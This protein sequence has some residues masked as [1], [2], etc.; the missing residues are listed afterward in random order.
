MKKG[1][2][3]NEWEAKAEEE[4]FELQIGDFSFLSLLDE[5]VRHFLPS[6]RA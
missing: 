6:K 4:K 1:D 2:W 5:I 3:K